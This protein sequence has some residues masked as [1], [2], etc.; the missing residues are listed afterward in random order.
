MVT[1]RPEW[2]RREYPFEPRTFQTP[3]GAALSYVDEG[4]RTSSDAVLLLHGNPTWSYFYR[5]VIR[6]LSS[7]VRCV[8][9]DHVGMGLS[10]KPQDYAYT[11]ETR[12]RD[13]EALVSH[14]GLGRIRLVV[15]D[16]G[17]AIG[18]GFATR[19]VEQVERICILNTAAFVSDRIPPSI[20]LCR[21]GGLGKLIVRGLNGFARPAT[22]MTMHARALTPEQKRGYLLPYD[23]WANRVAVHQFVA[24]IPMEEGHRTRPTLRAIEERLPLLARVPKRIV[25]GGRDFCFND[26][27]LE[28][29]RE[30]Y[31]DADVHRLPEAGHYVLDDGGEE[32][33]SLVR[34]FVR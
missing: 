31:P 15:H 10:G 19:H 18:F 28:R 23:S 21:A 8:A 9:P 33:R 24:D 27:F 6:G 2:L 34:D 5:D 20:A 22:W 30:I 4:P 7:E 11:L 12:I 14:L 25:W 1:G 29:W 3:G 16:W 13:V 32:A 17:G 26:H